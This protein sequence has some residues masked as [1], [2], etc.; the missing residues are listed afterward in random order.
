MRRFWHLAPPRS[1]S[2]LALAIAFL[3]FAD[4]GNAARKDRSK[5][6]AVRWDEQRPGCTFSRSD[7]GRYSYGMWSAG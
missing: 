1:V 5:M 6:P 3:L 2:L 4:P 7:D